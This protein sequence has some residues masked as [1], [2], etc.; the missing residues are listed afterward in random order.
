M[1]QNYQVSGLLQKSIDSG[2]SG[3]KTQKY[4]QFFNIFNPKIWD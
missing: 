2:S 4:Q 1:T 3:T